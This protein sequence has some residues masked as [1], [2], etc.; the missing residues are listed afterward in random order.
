MPAVIKRKKLTTRNADLQQG[1]LRNIAADCKKIAKSS[2]RFEKGK[3]APTSTCTFDLYQANLNGIQ[4]DIKVMDRYHKKN[5]IVT[6]PFKKH[7]K[8]PI[9]ICVVASEPQRPKK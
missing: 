5:G 7:R 8:Q 1:S 4:R 6:Y 3:T 9:V 2:E